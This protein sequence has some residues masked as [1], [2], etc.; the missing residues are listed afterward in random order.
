MIIPSS[1]DGYPNP[2]A[3]LFG[4]RV[5]TARCF[6]LCGAWGRR[7]A[8]AFAIGSGTHTIEADQHTDLTFFANDVRGFEW[9]N[10]GSISLT[11]TR[12]S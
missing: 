1:P 2:L 6:C 10:W 8:T 5:H 4:L 7:D 12:I 3:K 11:V 9:N